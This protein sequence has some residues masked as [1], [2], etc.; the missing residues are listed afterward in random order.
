MCDGE[1]I[2]CVSEERFLRK[3]CYQGYP[4]HSIDY[5]VTLVD[6]KEIDRVVIASMT[7]SPGLMMLGREQNFSIGDFIRQQQEHFHPVFYK[8]ADRH[9]TEKRFYDQLIKEKQVERAD[10]QYIVDENYEFTCDPEIDDPIFR[11]IRKNTVAKHLDIDESKIVHTD[12]HLGHAYYAYFASPFR[13]DDA[14]VITADGDGDY[15]INAT[16]SIAKNDKLKQI[17][18]TD[19]QHVGK[20][21]RYVTLILGMKPQQHEYKVMGLAPYAD[22]NIS[23]KAYEILKE[24][25][26]VDGIDF[27]YKTTPV[28]LY[29]YFLEKFEGIRFDGIAGGIQKWTEEIMEEWVRNIIAHTGINRI[30]FSGGLSM[31]IKMN[32]VIHEMPEVLEYYVAPSGGDESLAIGGCYIG[33]NTSRKPLDNIYLGPEY[34][35]AEMEQ[36]AHE[37]VATGRYSVESI[38][39]I[40]TVAEFLA[41]GKTV[42]RCSGRMEFGARALGN[43]SIFSDPS[44]EEIVRK[45]N[46]Q[47]KKRD[48][49]M[50]FTPAIL[51]ERELDYIVNP[52]G[53]SSPYMTIAFGST[54]LGKKEL[55]GAIHPYDQT[56]RPQ[57][58]EEFRN[59]GLYRMIK[60]FEEKTGIGALLN[61]SFNLHGEAIVM[62]PRDAL[63]TMDNSSLDFLLLNDKFLIRRIT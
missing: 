29:F 58:V 23:R 36:A 4:R 44:D 11:S 38:S 21:W 63:Y 1:I 45:I 27:K 56:I 25:L 35:D 33:S 10:S 57:L 59:P 49:W 6:K 15:G 19:K 8:G 42:A 40:G 24:H 48:F 61:T 7:L 62:S 46:T 3:K 17:L 20:I 2:A 30:V 14:V 12:H 50:P 32:K 31:N 55:K 60:S 28:D 47:I 53:I 26:V 9:V 34:S 18:R 51:K 22:P 16:V 5:L 41:I 52:K 13:G 43:R 39:D 54:D 37:A